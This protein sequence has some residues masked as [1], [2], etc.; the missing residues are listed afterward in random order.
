MG[1]EAGSLVASDLL[2]LA[3][4]IIMAKSLILT[5]L[6]WLFGG[7]FGLHH[8]YLNRDIQGFLWLCLPGGY[9]GLGWFRDLWRIPTYVREANDDPD[10]LKNLAEIM[11][12]KSKPPFSFARCF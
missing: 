6:L 10:Y 5:Y 9:F 8:F 12:A 2:V 3:S 11:R 7:N 4:R 1:V